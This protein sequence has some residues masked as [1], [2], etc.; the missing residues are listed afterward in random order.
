MYG[1][2]HP[3]AWV[4][5]HQITYIG[6][7]RTVYIHRIWPY[8]WWIPCQIYRIHTVYI[9]FWPT[10]HIQTTQGLS[11]NKGTCV[12]AWSLK[13]MCMKYAHQANVCMCVRV[14]VCVCLRVCVCVCVCVCACVCLWV[15]ECKSLSKHMWLHGEEVKKPSL[16]FVVPQVQQD[17]VYDT[18]KHM[19]TE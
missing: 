4:F 1:S 15:W 10:P 7:A 19:Y 3:Y 17:P 5:K 11:D 6:L 18:H 16:Q 8:I 12:C 13:H 14:C 9:W 2:G